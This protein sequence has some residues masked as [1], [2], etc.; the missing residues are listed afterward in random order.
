MKGI[1]VRTRHTILPAAA[2][3]A[4]VML[5]GCGGDDSN[6]SGVS[7]S[8]SPVVTNSDGDV[9][10]T[11][12][13]SDDTFSTSAADTADCADASPALKEG[14]SWVTILGTPAGVSADESTF[15]ISV[16]ERDCTGSASPGDALHQPFIVKTDD[17]VTLYMTMDAPAASATPASASASGAEDGARYCEGNPVVYGNVDIGEPLGKRAVFDGSTWPPTKLAGAPSD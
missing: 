12:A 8:D 3:L 16:A 4:A 1:N 2:V 15:E 11:C 6:N 10:L 9:M 5:S 14:Q 13:G 7:A 17:A